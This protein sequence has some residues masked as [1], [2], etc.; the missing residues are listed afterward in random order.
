MHCKLS[1][2]N[3]ESLEVSCKVELGF[4]CFKLPGSHTVQFLL[5]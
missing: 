2:H 3:M 1:L 5:L 4:V